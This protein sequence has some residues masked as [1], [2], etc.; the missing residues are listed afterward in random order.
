VARQKLRVN[1]VVD[2]N[3]DGAHATNADSDV[4]ALTGLDRFTVVRPCPFQ[5]RFKQASAAAFFR[6]ALEKLVKSVANLELNGPF[7]RFED[8]RIHD[9]TGQRLPPRGREAMPGCTKDKAG[10]KWVHGYSIK[11]GLL[12]HGI[13]DAETA[14]GT[15]LWHKLVPTFTSGALYLFD[16]GFFERALFASAKA[17]GVSPEDGLSVEGATERLRLG[18][19]VSPWF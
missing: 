10:A 18:L 19:D 2:A 14:S 12:E 5:K 4:G 6:T 3:L 13:C 17:A 1:G 8:V 15:P 7:G 11:T 9:G 16:L